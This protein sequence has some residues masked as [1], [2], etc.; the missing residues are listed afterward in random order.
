MIDFLL[1]IIFMVLLILPFALF[2]SMFLQFGTCFF[3]SMNNPLNPVPMF[4]RSASLYYSLLFLAMMACEIVGYAARFISRSRWLDMIK[5]FVILILLQFVWNSPVKTEFP[6][7]PGIDLKNIEMAF[8]FIITIVVAFR[9]LR[10]L[11]SVGIQ[12]VTLKNNFK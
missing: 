4:D 5:N 3:V 11:I 12:Q 1:K 9:F 7:I 2:L 10:N 6:K 8:V